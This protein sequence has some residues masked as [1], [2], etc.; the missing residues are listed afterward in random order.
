[1]LKKMMKEKYIHSVYYDELEICDG[2]ESYCYQNCQR[3]I[4][5]IE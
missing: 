2:Y 3:L 4:L 1:M 5:D